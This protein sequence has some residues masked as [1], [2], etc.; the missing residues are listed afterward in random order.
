[1][2]N[3]IYNVFT[4]VLQFTDPALFTPVTMRASGRIQLNTD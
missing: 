4:L 3:D 1:M 2:S